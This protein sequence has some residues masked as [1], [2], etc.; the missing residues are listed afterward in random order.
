MIVC[1]FVFWCSTPY[2]NNTLVIP[3]RPVLLGE[4][5]GYT[6]KNYFMLYRIHFA[7]NG[8][9]K[10][11]VGGARALIVQVVVNPTTMRSR[12]RWPPPGFIFMMTTSA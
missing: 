1:L 6:R 4:E 7:M 11:N 12:S 2:L 3:W 5:T 10:P 9:R 8:I